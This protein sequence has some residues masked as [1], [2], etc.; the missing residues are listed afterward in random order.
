MNRLTD[1]IVEYLDLLL[2]FLVGVLWCWWTGQ[3]PAR[4]N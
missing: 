2:T 4:R 3:R 1:G